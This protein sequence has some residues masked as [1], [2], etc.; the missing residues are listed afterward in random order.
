MR[1]TT[2][3]LTAAGFIAAALAASTSVNAETT[4]AKTKHRAPQHT[5]RV[6]NPPVGFAEP[7]SQVERLNQ[8][9]WLDP[10]TSSSQQITGNGPAYVQAQTVL[11][12][13]PSS[14]YTERLGYRPLPGAFDIPSDLGPFI[15]FWTPGP[16]H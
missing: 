16:P 2:L 9:S 6:A 1:K 14:G 10:G 3:A 8:R 4:D 11:N 5:T 13:N 15:E 7:R 12:T